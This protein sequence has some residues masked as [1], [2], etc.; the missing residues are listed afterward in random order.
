[1]FSFQFSLWLFFAGISRHTIYV[2][3]CFQFSYHLEKSRNNEME[4]YATLTN[5][6]SNQRV[7]LARSTCFLFLADLH[8]FTLKSILMAAEIIVQTIEIEAER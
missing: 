4:I 3:N 1:M 7:S 2:R 5:N 6:S 8:R